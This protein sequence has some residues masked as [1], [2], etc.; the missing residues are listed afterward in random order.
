[1]TDPSVPVVPFW[2][3]TT[4]ASTQTEGAAPAS[5]WLDWERSGHAPPSGDGNGFGTRFGDDFALLADHGLTHHRLTLEWARLEP[6]NGKPDQA[7][8]E[9]YREV[10]EVARDA[11]V[12]IWACLHHLSLPGW[13]GHDERG[14]VD[15]RSRT[16]FWPRHVDFVAET[17][18]DLI[19]GWVPV[20]EPSTY[21]LDGWLGGGHPP[22]RNDPTRFVEALETVHLAAF[23]AALRLRGAGAPVATAHALAPVQ[24]VGDDPL[25]P[26]WAR[27]LDDVL[28]GSWLGAMRDGELQVLDRGPIPRPELR[29]AFDIVGFTYE[30]ALGIDGAGEFRPYPPGRPVTAA[31]TV[32]WPEGLGVVLHRLAEEVPGM[33][34]MVSGYGI[35]TTDDGWRV[36]HLREGLDQLAEARRDGI[37]VRGF[38]HRTAVDGYEWLLG[39]DVPYGL[40]DR[41]RSPRPSAA[42]LRA[43]ATGDR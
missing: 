9:H 39:H 1:M 43:R 37:D 31:G 5:D 2:W 7:A 33:P 6:T 11:G 35:G 20:H 21:A 38:F 16:Y 40:F 8:V 25:A 24:A 3:G 14:F 17:F 22:G 4:S 42:L 32:P 15:A 28:W 30:G 36:D 29:E 27:R 18:G 26:A 13:F 12:S 19:A 23:E 34:L 10:L 41:D